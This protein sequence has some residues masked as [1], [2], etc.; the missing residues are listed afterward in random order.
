MSLLRSKGMVFKHMTL[1]RSHDE[2]DK[3]YFLD[4]RA[5]EATGVIEASD[6]LAIKALALTD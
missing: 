6:Y 3:K 2:C 1:L 5:F 4:G